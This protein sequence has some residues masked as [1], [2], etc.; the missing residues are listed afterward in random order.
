MGWEK[1]GGEERSEDSVGKDRA[2]GGRTPLS[3]SGVKKN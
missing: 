1:T 3:A 2:A